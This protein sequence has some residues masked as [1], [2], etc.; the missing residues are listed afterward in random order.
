MF[1][2]VVSCVED[3]SEQWTALELAVIYR[4]PVVLSRLVELWR[5]KGLTIGR[6]E[7]PGSRK[8]IKRKERDDTLADPAAR[9]SCG[10]EMTEKRVSEPAETKQK[11]REGVNQPNVE[12]EGRNP[13][14]EQKA[15]DR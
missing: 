6:C 2:F 9:K 5:S 15:C 13:Y 12:K 10:G 11:G 3:A 14:A 8:K 7:C 4:A 1:C